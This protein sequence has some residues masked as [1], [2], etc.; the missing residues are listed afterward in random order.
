MIP[1]MDCQQLYVAWE[2][3]YFEEEGLKVEGQTVQSGSMSQTLVESGS[4]DL[5]WTA[6]V[7]IS[8]AHVKGFDFAFIAPGSFVDG[9]NRKTVGMVVKKDS[10]IQSFKELAGKKVAINALQSINHLGVLVL[11]SLIHISEP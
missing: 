4:V 11:L 10:P 2:K 3:G 5:G 6:V 1:I 7:P 8:Q 9:T